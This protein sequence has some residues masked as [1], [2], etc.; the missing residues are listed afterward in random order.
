MIF[1]L[2]IDRNV[3]IIVPTISRVL[4]V[5][6]AD[7]AHVMVVINVRLDH[8]VRTVNLVKMVLRVNP[9]NQDS[10][11]CPA[12]IQQSTT[13]T[14]ADAENARTDHLAHQVHQDNLE[15]PEA[16]EVQDR[17][18]DQV[19]PV[20]QV[21]QDKEER[22]VPVN[23]V[24]PVL[25]V[26]QDNQ[27][28]LA[29]AANQD[30]KDRAAH[31]DRKDYQADQD[32]MAIK[33]KMDVPEHQDRLE[34]QA[35]VVH[36]AL[37]VNPEH[38]RHQAEMHRTAHVRV[39]KWRP[40]HVVHRSISTRESNRNSIVFNSV[41]IESTSASEKWRRIRQHSIMLII[42]VFH[43]CRYERNKV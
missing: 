36:P 26:L 9:V 24:D 37:Q 41:F 10:Q 27:E 34:H 31:Q 35:N 40:P 12:T 4:H 19:N 6:Q 7:N 25:Q 20:H 2:N 11:V 21:L 13:I 38:H 1:G 29:V 42:V 17:L 15:I 30:R 33:V 5:K 3:F 14:K 8:P 16:Q 28:P 23:Q 22:A 39:V 32:V 43:C 18:E